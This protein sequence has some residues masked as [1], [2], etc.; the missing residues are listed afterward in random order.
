MLTNSHS[1]AA[2]PLNSDLIA[3]RR[4]E[5]AAKMASFNAIHGKAPTPASSSVREPA[6][7]PPRP[8]GAGLD[9]DLARKVAEAKKLVAASL[10]T[11]AVKDNPYMVRDSHVFSLKGTLNVFMG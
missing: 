2:Q 6:P 7:L 10:A 9:P 1:V 8:A 5:I 3:Q 11:K 4:A